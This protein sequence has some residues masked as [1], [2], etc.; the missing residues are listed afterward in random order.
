MIETPRLLLRPMTGEDT[1][2]LL[3]IFSD[4]LVMHSFGGTL[5]DRPQMQ[6]WINRNLQ[7]Q[8]Q[9]GYGLFSVI[10]KDTAV[11]IG[12]CGL[13]HMEVEGRPEVEIGYDFRSDYWRQGFATEAA[14]AVRDFASRQ[15]GLPRLLSLIRPENVASRRV[16]GKVGMQREREIVRGGEPYWVYVFSGPEAD[17]T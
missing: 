10:L 8:E 1:D 9:Y 5:F 14:C 2:A 13:E 11:L 6:R 16:A 7:H 17:G 4:P 12:D 15:L 3:C